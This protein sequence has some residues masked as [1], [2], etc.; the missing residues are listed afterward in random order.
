M[1]SWF[2]ERDRV[3]QEEIE[4]MAAWAESLDKDAELYCGGGADMDLPQED[5]G[6]EWLWHEG[7][8]DGKMTARMA[9]DERIMGQERYI[10]MRDIYDCG[11][12]WRAE[13]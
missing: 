4:Q 3:W 13:V 10:G 6:L 9:E 1:S 8:G 12:P 11:A 7:D 2:E 5:D